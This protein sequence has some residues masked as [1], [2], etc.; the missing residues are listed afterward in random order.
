MEAHQGAGA[1]S[2]RRVVL[3]N[4]AQLGT[5]RRN[6]MVPPSSGP[7]PHTKGVLGLG[8]MCVGLQ[9]T[10]ENQAQTDIPHWPL[11]TTFHLDM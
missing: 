2:E 3:A 1:G 5:A 4:G 8:A 11:A 10:A 9:V 6:D 7:T